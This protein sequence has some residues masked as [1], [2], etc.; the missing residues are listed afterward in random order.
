MAEAVG[1]SSGGAGGGNSAP[2]ITSGNTYSVPEGSTS[3]GTVS[4]SDSDGDNLTFSLSGTD[5][6]AI[7]LGSTWALSFNAAAD[8][9]NP[10]DDGADNVYNV[11]VRVGD[12]SAFDARDLVILLLIITMVL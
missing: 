10:A 1:S 4:A 11:T 2:L 5:A 3:I 7:S 12:G 8:F 6:G 9:E